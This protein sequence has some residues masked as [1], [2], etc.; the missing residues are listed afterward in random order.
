MTATDLPTSPSMPWE[1]AGQAQRILAELDLDLWLIF[2]RE[3]ATLPDP[4]LDVVV[5]TNVT[6]SSAFLFPREINGIRPPRTA[7]VGSL[8]RPNMESQGVFDEVVGYVEGIRGPLRDA[9]CAIDPKR[10]AINTSR[11]TELADGLTHGM[12]LNLLEILDGTPYAARLESSAPLVARLRGRKTPA[13]VARVRRAI[14][15]TER[16]FGEMH[17]MLRPGLTEREVADF[18]RQQVADRGLLL[19]WDPEHCPAVFSGP[20]TAGAHAAPTDRRVAP[21]HVLNMDFGVKV[22]GY[23]ADLQRTIYVRKP[24]ETTAPAAVQRGFDVIR[25]AIAKS[26]AVLKP[27]ALGCDVDAVARGHIVAMGYAEYP[28]ALGHQVGRSAHD[29]SALLGPRWERYGGR[30]T[31]PVE[32]GQIYTLE[33]RLTIPGYGVATVEEMV[34]VTR[35]GVEFLSTP[36]T[37]LWYA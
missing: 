11:D 17:A 35:D 33:P 28:H 4:A 5:G 2:V 6:W 14:A 12:Y 16:I 18:V 27:G 15:E 7:I 30:V 26:A 31:E 9:I 19:A 29:G 22:D 25:D 32:E 8:D 34:Q 1:K 3:S 21:G 20:D 36:Q 24:D 23:C 10:I 37:E 13:E